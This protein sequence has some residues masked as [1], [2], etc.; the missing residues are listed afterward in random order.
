MISGADSTQAIRLVEC[1]TLPA[2]PPLQGFVD[3]IAMDL[4]ALIPA[5]AAKTREQQVMQ[6]HVVG[7]LLRPLSS[8]ER[9]AALMAFYR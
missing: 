8:K 5:F 7:L 2:H 3:S 9:C 1:L 6:A 4:L